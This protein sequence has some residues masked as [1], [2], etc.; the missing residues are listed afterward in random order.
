MIPMWSLTWRRQDF[1]QKIITSSRSERSRS[2]A[3]RIT[4]R[5]SRLVNPKE[6]IPFRTTELTSMPRDEDVIDAEDIA[7][8]HATFYGFLRGCYHGCP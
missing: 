4:E 2:V 1:M 8:I 6:P 5:F 3:G 7:K